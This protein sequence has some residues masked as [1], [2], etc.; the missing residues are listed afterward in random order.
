M[1]EIRCACGSKGRYQN[2][3]NGQFVI[4]CG[5]NGCLNEGRLTQSSNTDF[6]DG[7]MESQE[8]YFGIN[9]K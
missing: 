4:T 6:R 3:R 2:M 9:K 5:T 8:E 1:F 7:P